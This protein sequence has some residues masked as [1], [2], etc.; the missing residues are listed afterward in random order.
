MP[1]PNDFWDAAWK[2]GF[3]FVLITIAVL[4]F[5]YNKIYTRSSYD[6]M[7][8]RLTLDIERERQEKKD[9]LE[10]AKLNGRIAE[11]ALRKEE[12]ENRKK[13]Q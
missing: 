11:G 12:R 7:V 5:Y 4:L 2:V 10:A 3:P 1:D 13:I 8:K 9:A 6:E